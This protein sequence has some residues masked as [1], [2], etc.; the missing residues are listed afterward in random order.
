MRRD[1]TE[2]ESI[3]GAAEGGPRRS[4]IGISRLPWWGRRRI[5]LLL[6]GLIV[7]PWLP[8]SGT[9]RDPAPARRVR[10]VGDTAILT[11]AFAPV[12][13]T[14]AS[15][16]TDGRV[17]VRDAAGGHGAHSFLDHRGFAQ[18]LAFAP[19]GRSL[20]LGGIEPDILLYDVGTGGEARPL[21]IPIRSVR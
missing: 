16:Q 10:G 3:P 2:C 17:A 1:A 5:G 20:A 8:I 15:I 14:I 13:A 9:P 11:F 19:D 4:R 7:L 18:A 6:L 21:G 12:G